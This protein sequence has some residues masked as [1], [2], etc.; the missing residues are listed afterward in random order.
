MQLSQKKKKM[1]LFYSINLANFW[2][3]GWAAIGIF[4]VSTDIVQYFLEK[5]IYYRKIF[6]LYRFKLLYGRNAECSLD[7]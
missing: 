2:L 7:I 1:S 3:F 5:I 6:H 4:V